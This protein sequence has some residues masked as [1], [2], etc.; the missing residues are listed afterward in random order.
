MHS[1]FIMRHRLRKRMRKRTEK[2]KSESQVNK[3]H[4]DETEHLVSG[5]ESAWGRER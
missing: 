2:R 4:A 3:V 1:A 5:R